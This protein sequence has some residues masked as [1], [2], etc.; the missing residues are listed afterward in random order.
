MRVGLPAPPGVG[1]VAGGVAGATG[2]AALRV[3]LPAPP[4]LAGVAGEVALVAGRI[5]L[6]SP[7]G[8]LAGATGS[9]GMSDR[10]T[11]ELSRVQR[12]SVRSDGLAGN[13]RTPYTA[14]VSQ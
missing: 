7:P 14:P 3:G 1:R 9:G 6:F 8:G 12:E 2:V 11:A 10:A 4:G 13:A 5:G